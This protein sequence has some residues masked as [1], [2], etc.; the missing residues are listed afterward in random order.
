MKPSLL[1]VLTA[2]LWANLAQGQLPPRPEPVRP[3]PQRNAPPAAQGPWNNDVLVHRISP[4]GEVTKIA[5]FERAGVPTIARLKDGRLI[6][7]HQHFP[8]DNQADFDKVAVHFSS[9]EGKTWTKPEVIRVTGLPDGMRFPFDPTLVPLPDGNIRLYF[10]SNRQRQM[11]MAA[12]AIY[13]AISNNGLDY[14]VEPGTRFGIEGRPVIDCAVVLHQGLFHLFSPDNGAQRQGRGPGNDPGRMRPVDGVGY[15]ATSKDG[16]D[17]RR[18]EEVKIQGRR[19]WLGNAQSDGKNIIFI[20]TGEPAPG[21]NLQREPNAFR[22]GIWMAAS[23]D[24]TEWDLIPTAAIPGADPGAVKSTDGGWI[25]VSTG[26]PRAGTAGTDQRQPAFDQP[27]GPRDT[28][29]GEALLQRAQQA[30]PE[31]YRFAMKQGAKIVVTPDG[32][33]FA[34]VW[35]PKDEPGQ[36]KPPGIVCLHGS[37][38]FAFDEFFLWHSYAAQRGYGIIALQWWLGEGDRA[39]DYYAPREIYPP[40][41]HLL[42]Q[43]QIASGQAMIHGFSRGSANLYAVMALD[44]QQGQ[45]FRLAVANAGGAA[46]DFPPNL[47]MGRGDYGRQPLADTHWILFAGGRDPNPQRDGI[48]AMRRA[49]EWI[50]RC[51]GTVD[52]FIEDPDAG[53]G[54]FHQTPAHVNEALDCF[55]RLLKTPVERGVGAPRV[56]P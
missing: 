14:A 36:K 46:P 20:G 4:A 1:A 5:T 56:R 26:P 22:G 48:P 24:G 43:E 7:A 40:L 9:D 29:V 8:E 21:G 51:G 16:L 23:A 30:N 32:R 41:D 6:A 47:E 18:V 33:S 15:H 55:D 54:G 52:R 12:P 50:G 38:S 19:R 42:R 10:T 44:R 17:F 53:H 27:R 2:M 49:E 11:E 28:R 25:V 3:G 39:E 13:S 35:F 45:F 37:R 31:R 34:L